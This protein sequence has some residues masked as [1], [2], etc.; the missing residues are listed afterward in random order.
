MTRVAIIGNGGGGKSTLAL[1]MS[2]AL[3]LPYYPVDPVQW[4]PGWIPAPQAVIARWHATVLAQ[5]RWIIDGWGSWDL[6]AAR[7]A[8]ADTVILVDHPL[9]VHLWWALKRQA[10]SLV[11]PQ[12]GGPADCPL[13]P[14]TGRMLRTIWRVH[15]RY[16]PQLLTLIDALGPDKRVIRIHSPRQLRAFARQLPSTVSEPAG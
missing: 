3:N 12:A 8:A 5:D 9:A 10:W 11:H 15:R 1:G 2:N 7:L 6:I 14:V 13:L 16:R 4:Q